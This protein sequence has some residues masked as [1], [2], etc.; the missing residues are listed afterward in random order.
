[1][2]RCPGSLFGVPGIG[3]FDGFL[4]FSQTLDFRREAFL[5]PA[6]CLHA[7][8]RCFPGVDL[9]LIAGQ[10]LNLNRILETAF[11]IG[12]Q[13]SGRLEITLGDGQFEEIQTGG[14]GFGTILAGGRRIP[15]LGLRQVVEI[16]EEV[17]QGESGRGG[18]IEGL[19]GEQGFHRAPRIAGL[20]AQIGQ[21]LP[22]PG[23]LGIVLQVESVLLDGGLRVACLFK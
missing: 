20:P 10:L 5:F 13:L 18:W 9:S 14:I 4:L 11:K 23:I 8:L 3:R 15:Y 16:S 22:S 12:G 21:V 1:M 6:S 19:A 2:G 7:G 17:A